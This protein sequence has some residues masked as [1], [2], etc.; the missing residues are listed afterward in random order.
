V[1]GELFAD[2]LNG[3]LSHASRAAFFVHLQGCGACQQ[4]L[5][6]EAPELLLAAAGENLAS[7]APLELPR[8]NARLPERSRVSYWRI[9]AMLL[10]LFGGGALLLRKIVTT[11]DRTG[12]ELAANSTSAVHPAVIAP[13]ENLAAI[14]QD[15][16]AVESGADE[17]QIREYEAPGFDGKPVQWVRMTPES[18]PAAAGE[19]RS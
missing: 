4:R 13:V 17:F 8:L 10:I 18:L 19:A 14:H 11:P 12:V 2:L 9:A 3:E 5:L 6:A 16:P 1:T 15:Q 7:P